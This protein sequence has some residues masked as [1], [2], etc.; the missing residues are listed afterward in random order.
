MRYIKIY[1]TFSKNL[2]NITFDDLLKLGL[3][4]YMIGEQ[5]DNIS[6]VLHPE[7]HLIYHVLNEIDNKWNIKHDWKY[8]SQQEDNMISNKL[9]YEILHDE[10]FKKG[11]LEI[12][13]NRF[14][15]IKKFYT[16]KKDLELYR[17]LE[18]KDINSLNLQKLGSSWSTNSEIKNDIASRGNY[19]LVLNIDIT[20]NIINVYDTYKVILDLVYG[21][22]ED[23]IVLKKGKKIEC[24]LHRMVYNGSFY[25]P[26]DETLIKKIVG[27][28]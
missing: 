27:I 19:M 13:E 14:D 25:Q 4:E 20:S 2:L 6:G 7:D 10:F 1:E 17:F 28:I 24:E 22:K 15:D 9:R 18:L 3:Y 11:A 23:E 16:N 26:S 8:I 5:G 21:D 12:L